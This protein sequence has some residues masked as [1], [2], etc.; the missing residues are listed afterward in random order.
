MLRNAA[1]QR[2]NLKRCRASEGEARFSARI[3][4]VDQF[5]DYRIIA[6]DPAA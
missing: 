2:C 3:Q 6:G 4:Q 5:A 1:V